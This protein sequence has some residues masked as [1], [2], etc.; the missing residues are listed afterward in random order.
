MIDK[1]IE[2]ISDTAG[3][4]DN[5]ELKEECG[6][7]GIYNNDDLDSGRVVYYGLFSLQHRGQESCGIAVTDDTVVK[8]YKDMG[9]VPDV[10]NSDIL[11]NL[12]GKIA[13]GHVRYS[14][15]GG[16][17]RQNSQPLVSRYLKG[18][19]TISHNGNLVNALQLREKFENEGFIFQTTI[20]TE[21]I[22]YVIARERVK[23]PSIEE[24]ISRMMDIVEGSYALLVM[25]PKKLIGCRDPRGIRPLVIGK[26][27][28]SYILSSE[29]CAL[30]SVG[31]EFV[32]DVE[33]GEIVVIDETGLHSIKTH[34][35][36]KKT[37]LC[38]FEL[39][40]FARPDSYIEGI[41]VY[42]SRKEAG[43][44]LALEHPVDADLVIG[45]PDSGI[46]AAIG[47]SE[48]SGIP[49]GKGLV[50][51]RYIGRT[52]ISPTQSAR[53]DGVK[54][55]LN[56]LRSAVEGK[57]II[58]VDDSIVRGTTV[59]RLVKIL[60]NAGAKEVHMRVSSPPFMWPCYYGTDVPTRDKLIACRYS[61]D[62]IADVAGVDSLGYLGIDK[63]ESLKLGADFGHCDACFTGNYPTELPPVH[64]EE[65]KDN[66]IEIRKPPKFTIL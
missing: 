42:E 6:V 56:A 61:L 34:C 17:I 27:G 20:D 16:S 10:F 43:R 62:E 26:R 19:L 1:R 33:P 8:Q 18:A 2:T 54:I 49:Y 60:R 13:V 7:F 15:A 41:S 11:D 59:A 3:Y 23:N 25:S 5:D 28:N 45:V 51:N 57:R 37:A 66:E 12:T 14:T 9:L 48:Q 22:A 35:G 24:A 32:R 47:Y 50:K 39:I 63:L 64:E 4:S 36:K 29:S 53:E 65:E 30:D 21:V 40:Y 44:Q 38:I 52:F 55:K 58:M 46:D 31:A